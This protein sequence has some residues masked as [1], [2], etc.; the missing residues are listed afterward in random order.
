[1]FFKLLLILFLSSC[2]SS[3]S[4]SDGKQAETTDTK[5][6]NTDNGDKSNDTQ[7]ISEEVLLKDPSK[8]NILTV[9]SPN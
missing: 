6:T 9:L 3:K 7:E 2:G 1:M 8:E 5:E 4:N